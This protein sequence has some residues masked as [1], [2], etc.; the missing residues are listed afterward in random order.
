MNAIGNLPLAAALGAALENNPAVAA[1][2]TA[3]EATA[4]PVTKGSPTLTKAQEAQAAL[5]G[6]ALADLF[7]K[8]DTM[9]VSIWSEASALARKY[10]DAVTWNAV[11][12]EA[13]ARLQ[14]KGY[15][16]GWNEAVSFRQYVSSLTKGVSNGIIPHSKESIHKYRA[17]LP[18]ANRK[19]RETT[20]ASPEAQAMAEEAKKAAELAGLQKVDAIKDA[21]KASASVDA[22]KNGAG[23][24]ARGIALQAI[25]RDLKSLSDAGV[26]AV[27]EYVGEL[28]ARERDAADVGTVEE[29]QNE[30]VGHTDEDELIFAQGDDDAPESDMDDDAIIN[31]L[32]ELEAREAVAA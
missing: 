5:G 13:K 27:A 31:E 21:V 32:R 1:A 26:L 11:I 29:Q 12:R 8:Y 23:M 22:I 20:Q 2:L 9:Q 14:A 7:V 16:D 28:F 19:P 25:A 15:K 10:S 17:R 30:I 6:I 3:P 24:D 4:N 18:Q